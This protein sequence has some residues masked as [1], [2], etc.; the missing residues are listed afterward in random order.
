MIKVVISG[1]TTG[2]AW[3]GVRGQLEVLSINLAWLSASRN[4]LQEVVETEIAIEPC[5]FFLRTLFSVQLDRKPCQGHERR[6]RVELDLL[7]SDNQKNDARTASKNTEEE[8]LSHKA[9]NA[10]ETGKAKGEL[11]CHSETI[12]SFPHTGRDSPTGCANVRLVTPA[13]TRLLIPH[14]C[15]DHLRRQAGPGTC[16]SQ[17]NGADAVLRQLQASV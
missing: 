17:Q 11:G 8:E 3:E 4:L 5:H 10:E 16:F 9:R 15:L 14:P 13:E 2:Q 1:A 12:W 7:E 6:G